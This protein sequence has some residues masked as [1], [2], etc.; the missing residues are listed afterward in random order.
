[1]N[2]QK[3]NTQN[4][5]LKEENSS[6][7]FGNYSG[8]LVKSLFNSVHPCLLFFFFLLL[9][10]VFFLYP[11]LPPCTLASICRKGSPSSSWQW[12]RHFYH[13]PVDVYHISQIARTGWALYDMHHVVCASVETCLKTCLELLKSHYLIFLYSD[14]MESIRRFLNV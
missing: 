14:L 11:S 10:N 13:R 7:I 4:L 9:S 2:P 6:F 1:M 5:N 3:R 12:W 8:M